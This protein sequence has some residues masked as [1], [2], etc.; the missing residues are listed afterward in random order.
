MKSAAPL[1][2]TFMLS[3]PKVSHIGGNGIRWMEITPSV[4]VAGIFLLILMIWEL[5]NLPQFLRIRRMKREGQVILG[6]LKGTYGALVRR[7]SGKGRHT[8]YDV[9]VYYQFTNP[10]E[11]KT[12]GNTTFVRNDLKK[13]EL[14]QSGSVAILYVSDT[15]YLVL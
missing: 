11:R 3:D 7:G 4:F 6:Q 5:T 8:D 13:D 12:E 10:S 15:D 14:P 1:P 9:T 2:V